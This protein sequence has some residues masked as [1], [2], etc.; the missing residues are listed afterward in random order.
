MLTIGLTF[1]PIVRVAPGTAQRYEPL[2]KQNSASVGHRLA[3]QQALGMI[4]VYRHNE[5]LVGSLY[6]AAC[7]VE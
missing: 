7:I 2:G 3:I 4:V 5:Q 1:K 6:E